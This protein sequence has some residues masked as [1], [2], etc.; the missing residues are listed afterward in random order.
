VEFPTR[1]AALTAQKARSPASSARPALGSP[2]LVG[3]D[4]RDGHRPEYTLPPSALRSDVG[5]DVRNEVVKDLPQGCRMRWPLKAGFLIAH[6]FGARLLLST[7]R[8]CLASQSV[9]LP[10]CHFALGGSPSAGGLL[11]AGQSACSL[12]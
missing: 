9:P 11:G 8:A 3:P 12:P 1:R 6:T 5:K 10:G 7:S 4:S 2:A